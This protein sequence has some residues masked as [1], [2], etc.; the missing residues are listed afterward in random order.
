MA[1]RNQ[2]FRRAAAE[3][4]LPLTHGVTLPRRLDDSPN[5]PVDQISVRILELLHPIVLR[6]HDPLTIVSDGNCFYRSVSKLLFRTE[7]HY[8]HLRLLASIE[9]A[10]N[11]AYYDTASRHHIDLVQDYRLVLGR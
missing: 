2:V 5:G 10:M 11:P 4:L 8:L 3:K 7:D 9:I 6:D 1:S